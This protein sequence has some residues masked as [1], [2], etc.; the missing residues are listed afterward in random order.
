MVDLTRNR[1]MYVKLLPQTNAKFL[2]EILQFLDKWVSVHIVDPD[3]TKG[4]I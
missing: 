2:Y 3:Q 4:A 1:V